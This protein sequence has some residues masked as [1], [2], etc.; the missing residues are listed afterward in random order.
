MA[1][2]HAALDT[3]GS[4]SAATTT[5]AFGAL[6][7]GIRSDESMTAHQTR[8]REATLKITAMKFTDLEGFLD[9]VQAFSIFNKICTMRDEATNAGDNL[10]ASVWREACLKVCIKMNEDTTPH[11]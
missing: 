5:A 6:T 4:T 10:K 11:P 2:I 9:S 8:M 3:Q 7:N 1:I